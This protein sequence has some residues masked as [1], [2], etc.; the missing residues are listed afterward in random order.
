M[1]F[2]VFLFLCLV[3][4]VSIFSLAM[5]YL[6]SVRHYSVEDAAFKIKCYIKRVGKG[7][8]TTSSAKQ[9]F[10]PVLV[11]YDG[12]RILPR[13]VDSSFDDLRKN[14]Q[15][16]FCV[17]YE[18]SADA[19][20]VRYYFDILRKPDTTKDDDILPLLQ[21]QAEETLTYTMRLHDCYVPAEPL[22]A[23]EL[24]PNVLQVTF[25]QNDAGIQYIDDIKHKIRKRMILSNQQPHNAMR[26]K[27]NDKAGQ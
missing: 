1:D 26:E 14:F 16:C 22:T 8:L 4:S 3:F 5:L 27:W 12:C 19:S 24:Y 21:K 9:S 11:G 6:T 15:T 23:V 17:N 20:Y 10:Y 7:L 13:L 18:L 2:F 25:A